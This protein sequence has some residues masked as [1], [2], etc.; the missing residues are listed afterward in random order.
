MASRS[1]RPPRARPLASTRPTPAEG[2]PAGRWFAVASPGLEGAVEA[3]LRALEPGRPLI[4]VPGGV[5]FEA[6]PDEARALLPWLRI[7]SRLWRR[8]GRTRARAFGEL[9]RK[10]LALP[11]RD[12]LVPGQR[13]RVEVTVH[14][15]RLYHTGA[16]RQRL[17]EAAE[18]ALGAALVLATDAEDDPETTEVGAFPDEPQRLL[19]R[20][21]ADAFTVSVDAS[22]ERL[23]RRGY[24][25][26]VGKA[27]L[28]ETLAAGLLHLCGWSAEEALVDPMCGSGTL[29]IE[30][31]LMALQR[32]PPR[33]RFAI[34]GW[35]LHAGR[36][37]PE[38]SHATR[39]GPAVDPSHLRL[40]GFDR[41]PR[42]V[43]R[44]Q[45]NAERAGVADAIH[46]A[47][48]DFTDLRPLA[49]AGL[50]LFNPPYGHR[51]GHPEGE[52]RAFRGLAR[53]LSGWVGW[54]A[55]VLVPAGAAL[56]APGLR[57]TARHPLRNGGLATELVMLRP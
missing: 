3:E 21:E 29:P 50:L 35:P 13:I 46:F 33:V 7:T 16:L 47:T 22:G 14:R 44:A 32:S 57:E 1:S 49:P 51:L 54:R 40:W 17:V 53:T 34:D 31:A 4:P 6:T 11:W 56:E 24:R 25:Q 52:A 19:V 45:R 41:D 10:W 28:R 23:H 42:M 2:D 43:A 48:H 36:V 5:E 15:C 9:E 30:A 55:G 27:P 38:A 26:E 39:D 20:G 18:R 12:Y 8:L 37:A